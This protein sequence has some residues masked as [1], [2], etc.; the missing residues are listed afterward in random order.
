LPYIFS[1]CPAKFADRACAAEFLRRIF[2][3]LFCTH[4]ILRIVCV[5]V[6]RKFA[7][8]LI[9]IFYALDILSCPSENL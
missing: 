9:K 4:D 1:L 5:G 6:G 3:G 2:A 7:D 8:L